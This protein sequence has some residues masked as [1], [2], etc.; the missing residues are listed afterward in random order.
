MEEFTP[1]AVGAIITADITSDAADDLRDFYTSVMGW[2]ASP[3]PMGEYDDYVMMGPEGNWAAGV[4]HLRGVNAN[5]PANQWVVC[6]RFASVADSVAQ[7]TAG[8]GSVVG[9][10]REM[11]DGSR[12]AV[13]QDPKGGVTSIIEFPAK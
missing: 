10:V 13:I 6:F 8:G 5:Q 12:Y 4:C 1:P 3:M 11:G 2:Q 7:V 9:E